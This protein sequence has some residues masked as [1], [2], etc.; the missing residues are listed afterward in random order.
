MAAHPSNVN[1]GVAGHPQRRGYCRRA[2]RLLPRVAHAKSH[3]G[4]SVVGWG[5]L[6]RSF[7][8][9]FFKRFRNPKDKRDFVTAG[10]S[11]RAAAD[12]LPRCGRVTACAR[13]ALAASWRGG[14]RVCASWRRTTANC[15]S[16]PLWCA[17]GRGGGLQRAHRRSAVCLRGGGVLLA[18]LAGV[19]GAR[20]LFE[21][22]AQ[23]SRSGWWLGGESGCHAVCGCPAP[24][25]ACSRACSLRT[26]PPCRSS[27]RACAPRWR[28][29]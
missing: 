27:S 15:V 4:A 26:K 28:S 19:A 24:R 1:A 21:E 2:G 23:H 7:S 9:G 13:R 20:A 5:R 11:V 25:R 3:V 10:V 17:G 14:R 6:P 29:T 22:V 18:A 16:L 12:G 8:T